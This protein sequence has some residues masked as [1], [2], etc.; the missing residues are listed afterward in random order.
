M[1]KKFYLLISSVF[2]FMI[3]LLFVFARVKPANSM[4]RNATVNT[5][6][7]NSSTNPGN[8]ISIDHPGIYDSLKLGALGLSRQAYDYGY[9]QNNDQIV[10]NNNGPWLEI[11]PV[12]PGYIVVPYYDPAVVYYRPWRPGIRV[13][14]SF[15]Y[16]VALGG[17]FNPWGWGGNRFAWDRHEMYVNNRVWD[18]RVI[19]ERRVTTYRPYVGYNNDRDR[20]PEAGRNEQR[21]GS[22]S[23]VYR[24][25]SRP[26]NRGQGQVARPDYGRGQIGNAQ[27]RPEPHVL[28][29]RSNNERRAAETG[30][31]APR[32][33]HG[34]EERH[35]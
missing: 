28:Q 17:F 35:R 10:V 21:G 3:H 18:R 29:G 22:A 4:S 24:P 31:P 7:K 12:N 33:T 11:A 26:E 34:R 19:E 1:T 30:R 32:E 16:G 9:L 25:E 13:G 14:I 2:I 5:V 20:R 23:P 27:P 15:G 8:P 6:G